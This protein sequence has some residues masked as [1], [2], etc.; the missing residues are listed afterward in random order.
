MIF[1]IALKNI[2]VVPDQKQIIQST[3]WLNKHMTRDKL[4]RYFQCMEEAYLAYSISRIELLEAKRV[5]CK[6]VMFLAD[7]GICTNLLNSDEYDPK[8]IVQNIIFLEAKRRGYTIYRGELEKLDIDF[9]LQR[10][11]EKLYI[12]ASDHFTTETKETAIAALRNL[13]D[14]KPQY[15][16]ALEKPEATLRNIRCMD[17]FEFLLSPWDN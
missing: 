10:G 11:S 12:Q 13:W 4:L 5:I 2:G 1:R 15:L 14:F 8:Y 3:K 7:H 16:V 6:E 17:L 9:V